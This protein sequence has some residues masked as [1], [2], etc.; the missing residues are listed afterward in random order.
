MKKLFV[1]SFV[2]LTLSAVGGQEPKQSGEESGF[3][4]THILQLIQPGGEKP[5]EVPMKLY[6]K[7]DK[8]IISNI[9]P[10]GQLME[11]EYVISEDNK[12]KYQWASIRNDMVVVIQFVGNKVD[13]GSFE[14]KYT[15]LVDGQLRDDMSGRFTLEEIDSEK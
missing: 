9:M 7:G 15:A 13:D 4:P 10:D 6:S 3:V 1:I 2:L 14:G 8:K 12:I 11:T 5:V